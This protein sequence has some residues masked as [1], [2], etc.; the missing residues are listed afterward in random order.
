MQPNATGSARAVRG[1][2][3]FTPFLALFDRG[4][5][6]L[7]G[8]GRVTAEVLAARDD[9][10]LRSRRAPRPASA[11]AEP[12]GTVDGVQVSNGNHLNHVMRR[13]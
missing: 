11:L 10:R 4:H 12:W 6:N 8:C 13:C 3:R 2:H 5:I 9:H 1:R 7:Y